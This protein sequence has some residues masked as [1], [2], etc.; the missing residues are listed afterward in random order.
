MHLDILG[1]GGTFMGGIALLAREAGYTV[2]GV[3][4]AVYPPM[5]TLLAEQGIAIREGYAPRPPSL[6]PDC[7]LVGNA[8]SRGNP[9][10]EQVLDQRLLYTSGPQW[11][12]EEVMRERWVLAVT[13][14][15]GKT[16]TSSLLAW[17]LEYAGLSPGFLIGGVPGN[18]GYSARLGSGDLFVIEGDEYDT[19]FFDKRSK[20]I[21]FRP[22]TV[23]INNLEFDHADIFPDLAAIQ[24]QFHYLIRTVPSTGLIIANGDDQTITDTLALGCWTPVIRFGTGVNN[25]WRLE[26]IDGPN[27]RA[28]LTGKGQNRAITL[29]LPGEHNARNIL[30]A[31]LAAQHTGVT[32][33]QGIEALRH[34]RGV[35]RRLERRGIVGGVE[36][37]DDF[38]HHPTA[39]AATIAALRGR[40]QGRILAV[41]EPRSNTMRLGVHRNTL[42][43]SLQQ[44]DRVFV[45]RPRTLEWNLEDAFA[46]LLGER[47]LITEDIEC[48]I[49][50][51]TAAAQIGDAVLVM[52]NGAFENIHERLLVALSNQRQHDR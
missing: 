10:L 5:S 45:Y 18:F 40:H 23:V 11:L 14:T 1:I 27:A 50:Y 29:P 31:L 8:L 44:A 51:I 6:V 3:D 43:A 24:R 49:D 13:G 16:T 12:A 41:L 32:L 48:L 47:A 17:I 22:R 33:D 9:A 39:I 15:H 21:H 46:P 20:F 42:A 25:D 28:T 37:Y 34:F 52:S 19:A 7:V 30:A 4:A 36:L 38:A 26:A 2:S 35:R